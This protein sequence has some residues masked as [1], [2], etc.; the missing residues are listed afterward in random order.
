[1]VEHSLHINMDGVEAFGARGVSFSVAYRQRLCNV[2]EC[3]GAVC[4]AVLCLDSG[5]ANAQHYSRRRELHVGLGLCGCTFAFMQP[6]WLSVVVMATPHCG[7]YHSR[8]VCVVS[9]HVGVSV[10]F[11]G[12]VPGCQAR[13]DCVMRTC[14]VSTSFLHDAM[15]LSLTAADNTGANNWIVDVSQLTAEDK[16]YTEP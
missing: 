15:S 5:V 16:L 10:M 7:A 4:A 3:D 1:M 14:I 9:S 12:C 8:S 11:P 2:R 6:P 13:L